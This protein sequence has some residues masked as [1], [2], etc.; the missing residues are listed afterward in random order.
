[1]SCGRFIVFEGLDGVGK[2]TQATRLVGLLREKG[3]S[4][5][6]AREPGGTEVG[7]RIRVLVKDGGVSIPPEAELFLFL[8]ARAALTRKVVEPALASGTWV[9][10]ERFD[11]STFAY[12]GWGRGIDRERVE[13]F[14]R[15]ATGGRVPDLCLVL[16]VSIEESRARQRQRGR[17]LG[18]KVG[19]QRILDAPSSGIPDGGV[20]EPL[21]PPT[22]PSDRIEAESL[23]FLRR[24]H[25]G[26]IEGV[27]TMDNAVLVP[28][29]GTVEDVERRVRRELGLRFPET[30]GSGS[31]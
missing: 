21:P 7:E 28:A 25:R 12:Q 29:D 18:E 22:V 3:L 13:A 10:S 19:E 8:A 31:T 11:M 2:T 24:V 30:L 4:V 6:A 5:V 15:Y 17:R 1:M 16:D 20:E 23:D 26:Y 27:R 9:V 14:N